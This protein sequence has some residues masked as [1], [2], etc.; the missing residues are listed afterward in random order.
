METRMQM[1]F[2]VQSIVLHEPGW[3]LNE[4]F[5]GN[6]PEVLNND[7]EDIQSV[8]K[9]VYMIYCEFTPSFPLV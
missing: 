5:N 3:I 4:M 2:K 9:L 8:K 6:L 7:V 1:T